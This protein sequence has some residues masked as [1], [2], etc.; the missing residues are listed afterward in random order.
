MCLRYR[1]AIVFRCTIHCPVLFQ[2]NCCSVI[3]QCHVQ[4]WV[5]TRKSV[6]YLRKGLLQPV[7]YIATVVTLWYG[8][9]ENFKKAAALP[10]VQCRPVVALHN[11]LLWDGHK[12]QPLSVLASSLLRLGALARVRCL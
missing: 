6:Y 3:V 7:V 4:L 8:L 5:G 9:D 12:R 11:E 10:A 2:R 1:C